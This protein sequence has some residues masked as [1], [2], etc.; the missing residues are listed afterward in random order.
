[1][2]FKCHKAFEFS[3]NFLEKSLQLWSLMHIRYSI[4][5][6]LIQAKEVFMN[7][8]ISCLT[9]EFFGS[10]LPNGGN[11]YHPLYITR[12]ISFTPLTTGIDAFHCLVT[13]ICQAH[14]EQVQSFDYCSAWC[15]Q[16]GVLGKS[17]T[18]KVKSCFG[19]FRSVF[20]NIY[21]N[22]QSCMFHFI[23]S[24]WPYSSSRLF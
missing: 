13:Q 9:H 16:A 22:T 10:R 19:F 4:E 17:L 14:W 3:L 6:K 20:R 18:M 8:L 2:S 23:H 7:Y 5:I 15:H 11:R 12:L 24:S 21:N 1:M